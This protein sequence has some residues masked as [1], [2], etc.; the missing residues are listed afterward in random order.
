MLPK[1]PCS[2]P[3]PPQYD[4]RFFL[5]FFLVHFILV[6]FFISVFRCPR[7]VRT[8]LFS[9]RTHPPPPIFRG[10]GRQ[11]R[12]A[13]KHVRSSSG[14]GQNAECIVQST[15]TARSSVMYRR[16]Q[17]RQSKG[18]S[19]HFWLGCPPAMS[20]MSTPRGK[21]GRFERAAVP[22]PLCLSTHQEAA[23]GEDVT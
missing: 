7:Y 23:C 6:V 1:G 8:F 11:P 13:L 21:E 17:A 4:G 3:G 5:S 18:R 15:Y 2:Q 22:G 20:C 9:K 12:A 10:A 14:R 19:P 16:I